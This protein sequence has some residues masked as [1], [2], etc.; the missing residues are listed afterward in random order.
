MTNNFRGKWK[1][2]LGQIKSKIFI[3][4]HICKFFKKKKV[5]KY[6]KK[7]LINIKILYKLLCYDYA[8]SKKHSKKAYFPIRTKNRKYI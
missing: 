8:Q 1:Q 4:L 5:K 6:G 7:T 2:Q 3:Y